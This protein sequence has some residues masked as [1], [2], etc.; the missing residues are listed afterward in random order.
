MSIV[1]LPCSTSVQLLP[2]PPIL[3]E[4]GPKSRILS[5]IIH[6]MIQEEPGPPPDGGTRA[7]L[8][9]LAGFLINSITWGYSASFGVYQ[10]HYT[11]SLS[12]PKSQV[13]WIGSIQV[14]LTFFVGTLSGRAAD[15]GYA[16]HTALLGSVMIVLGTFITSLA[17]AYWQVFLTQGLCTGLGM[18]VLFMP[19]VAVISS[20][21]KRNKALALALAGSGSGVGSVIF[22]L[23]VQ[24]LQPTLGFPGAVRV[25]GYIALAFAIII[26]LLLRPRLPPRRSGPL[27]EWHAFLELPYVLFTIGMFLIFWALY[28]CSFYINTYATSITGMS[29]ESAADLLVII[30]AV[31]TP[32]RPLLGF[33]AD[34]YLDPLKTLILSATFLTIM[35]YTWISVRGVAGLYVWTAFYGAASGGLQG[36]QYF[37]S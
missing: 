30:N 29:P 10:L 5:L 23:I 32:M 26:N 27:I 17:T 21:W 16:Q 36:S 31:G 13:S 6:P 22:P 3:F 33:I 11:T 35:L 24:R 25:Q 28:F 1:R 20:Y 7:W 9:I 34:R 2:A 4:M 15:A 14:F 37:L 8:Q 12:L 18:G 19:A